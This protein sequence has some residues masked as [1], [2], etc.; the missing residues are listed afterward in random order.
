[1]RYINHNRY[2]HGIL[3]NRQSRAKA[4]NFIFYGSTSVIGFISHFRLTNLC[5][6]KVTHRHD[7]S[8][9]EAEV[10]QKEAR[11][12]RRRDLP[13]CDDEEEGKDGHDGHLPRT[14]INVTGLLIIYVWI[15]PIWARLTFGFGGYICARN[16][17]RSGAI[18]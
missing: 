2:S 14:E 10:G 9:A 18:A 7:S 13:H 4:L 1:M 12:R 6:V 8:R 16:D 17:A 5:H 11:D 15:A 3:E